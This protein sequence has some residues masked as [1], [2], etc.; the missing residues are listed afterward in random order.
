MLSEDLSRP[1]KGGEPL[2]L[3]GVVC[4]QKEHGGPSVGNQ[5]EGAVRG[6]LL[7]KSLFC[8][9]MGQVEQGFPPV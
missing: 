7:P 2:G 6:E 8:P 4:S 3:G 9:C 5:A 1:K